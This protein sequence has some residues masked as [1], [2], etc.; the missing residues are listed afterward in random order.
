[1]M[2][3]PGNGFLQI[4]LEGRVLVYKHALRKKI[5]PLRI[6]QRPRLKLRLLSACQLR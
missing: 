6:D 2:A 5:Q 4:P 3:Q 1:M